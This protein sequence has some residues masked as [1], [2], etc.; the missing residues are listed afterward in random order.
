MQWRPRINA[1]KEKPRKAEWMTLTEGQGENSNTVA[2]SGDIH[3]Q[4]KAAQ[5]DDDINNGLMFY[6]TFS[7]VF[8]FLKSYLYKSNTTVSKYLSRFNEYNLQYKIVL[9]TKT[10]IIL[11]EFCKIVHQVLD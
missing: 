3:G 9:T 1:A 11:N 7:F 4:D 10:I 8:A 5:D 6:T 2:K